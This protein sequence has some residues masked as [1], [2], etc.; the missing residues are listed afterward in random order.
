MEVEDAVNDEAELL[1]RLK[2]HA[3]V[4]GRRL[5]VWC[6][7]D[8]NWRASVASVSTGRT[9]KASGTDGAMTALD[10]ALAAWSEGVDL[11]I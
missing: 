2:A 8:G 7:D 9:E 1:Q 6:A 11:F 4:N 10:A 5:Q 3:E